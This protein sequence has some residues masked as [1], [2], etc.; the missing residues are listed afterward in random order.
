MKKVVRL[1]ESELVRIIENLTLGYELEEKK[2]GS[3]TKTQSESTPKTANPIAKKTFDDV[4]GHLEAT[5]GTFTL[6]NRSTTQNDEDDKLKKT[7][8]WKTNDEKVEIVVT[9]DVKMNPKK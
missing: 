4:V 9:L 1:T 5:K 2:E 8:K 6:R 7:W 3:S